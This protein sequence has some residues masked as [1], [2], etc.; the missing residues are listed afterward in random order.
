MNVTEE[1]GE[2]VR[3]TFATAPSG[4][5]APRR[6]LL[7]PAYH[8]ART[9]PSPILNDAWTRLRTAQTQSCNSRFL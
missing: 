8:V 3:I 7:Q 9:Y 2:T 1:R 6:V 5:Y 4:G